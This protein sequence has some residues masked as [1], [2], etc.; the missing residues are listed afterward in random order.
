MSLQRRCHALVGQ[1]PQANAAVLDRHGDRVVAVIERD[2]PDGTGI[3]AQR[4]HQFG[5]YSLRISAAGHERSDQQT[6]GQK[7]CPNRRRDA[8]ISL[9][10]FA[11]CDL[12]DDRNIVRRRLHQCPFVVQQFRQVS[13]R[14]NAILGLLFEQLVDR[15]CQPFGDLGIQLA[16][17]PLLH[18]GDLPQNGECRVSRKRRLTGAHLVQDGT[19]AEQIRTKIGLFTQCLFRCHVK[20]GPAHESGPG[21][22]HIVRHASQAE[23][24]QL[25]AIVG[26]FQQ[27]VS[28]LDVAMNQSLRMSR[29]Q[30]VRGLHRDAH[31]FVQRQFL[32]SSQTLFERL[33][34]DQLHHQ[35]GQA[36]IGG[37]L[38]L[39][40]SDDVFVSD[41]GG[42]SSLAAESLSRQFIVGQIRV[43]HLQSDVPLKLRV[44]RFQNNSHPPTTEDSHD[45]EMCQSTQIGGIGGW[46]Q[47]MQRHFARPWRAPWNERLIEI[48]T[49]FL[50][51]RPIRRG[52]HRFN[53]KS[54]FDHLRQVCPTGGHSLQLRLAAF[55]RV[56]VPGIFLLEITRKRSL[57]QLPKLFDFRTFRDRFHFNSPPAA[58]W[59]RL[60]L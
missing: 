58:A 11:K 47:K 30:A 3:R 44:K 52:F 56:H 55:A 53:F 25:H 19:K 26:G 40:D 21:Q 37:F 1:I 46:L 15:S 50:E 9:G 57:D 12:A 10:S 31:D 43:Q 8:P 28:G 6:D 29:H 38:D 22:F 36:F 4:R 49:K 32:V 20:R 34:G 59:I 39:I 16:Q 7:G 48:R 45:I 14:L 54:T 23:V 41:R 60:L 5:R 27:N 51:R 24:G 13:G 2:R 35:I 17:W 33:A 18:F 42:R